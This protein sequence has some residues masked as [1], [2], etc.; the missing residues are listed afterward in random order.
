MEY[1]TVGYS[2]GKRVDVYLDSTASG[3][4]IGSFHMN[5]KLIHSDFINKGKGWS[6]GIRIRQLKNIEHLPRICLPAASRARLGLL[7]RP[8]LPP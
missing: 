8:A 7:L 4:K 2:D 1:I 5:S 3:S 6:Y